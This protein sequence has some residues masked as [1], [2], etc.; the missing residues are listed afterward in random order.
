MSDDA[1]AAG[2]AGDAPGG[3]EGTP[4]AAAAV[5]RE[6]DE[7]LAES[8]RRGLVLKL[9]GLGGRAA[10]LLPL[11]RRRRRARPGATGRP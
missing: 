7:L 1:P 6:A 5:L 2:S 11:S 8:A 9:A 4:A 3:D 10:A